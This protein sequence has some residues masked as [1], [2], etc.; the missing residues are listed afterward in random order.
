MMQLHQDYAKFLE[1]E[2]EIL[3]IGPEKSEAFKKTVGK[4]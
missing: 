4:A 2:I 1:N 3:V